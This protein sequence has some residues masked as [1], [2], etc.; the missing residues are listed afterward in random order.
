MVDSRPP[1]GHA[2]AAA[3]AA[4]LLYAVTL[5]PTAWFWDSGECVAAAATL[6]IAHPPG[7]PFFVLLGKVWITLLSPTGL[8]V[9]VRMNL[10]AAT[11]SAAATGIPFL[12]AHRVLTGWMRSQVAGG[13]GGRTAAVVPVAGAW[14][15]AILAATAYT[16]W[17]QSNLNEKGLYAERAR[18]RSRLVAGDPLDGPEGPRGERVA[19]G[20]GRLRHG[21][22]IHEPPDVSASRARRCAARAL[23]EAGALSPSGDVC[24]DGGSREPRALAQPLPPDPFDPGSGDQR[25]GADLRVGRGRGGRRR[26]ARP[27]GVPRARRQSDARAVRE[28]LH[29]RRSDH[30]IVR[31]AAAVPRPTRTPVPQLLPV[32]RLAVGA[33]ARVLRAA[34][35]RKDPRL[36]RPSRPRDL[37]ARSQPGSSST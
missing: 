30:R 12:V 6:G 37:E 1:S 36:P 19:P 13:S 33:R 14:A 22:R 5:A 32:L 11:S 17:N 27:R 25:R 10:L 18:D 35:H 29:S 34:W 15:G 4:L 8:P 2:V 24:A 26:L 3:A 21:A 7:N 31:S 23:R 20:P 9:A 16:V 28:A